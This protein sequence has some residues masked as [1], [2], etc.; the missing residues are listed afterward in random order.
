MTSDK[1]KKIEEF[2]NRIHD[3][4]QSMLTEFSEG[5]ISREQF[6]A[7]YQHYNN[8]LAIADEAL[9]SGDTDALDQV[10]G[11]TLSIRQSHMGLALGL[12]IYHNKSGTLVDTLGDFDVP[13]KQISRVLNDFSM[14]MERDQF[15]EPRVEKV[16]DQN[17][18]LYAPGQQTTVVTLFRNEPSQYQI[19]EIKRLHHDFEIANAT[20]L[21]AAQVDSRQLAYPFLVFVQ[22]KLGNS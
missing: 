15:I 5:K 1:R 17:W 16:D 18:L 9:E 14:L 19:N 22:Q 11:V 13:P 3:K 10:G 7:V 6:N 12:V 4:M 20:L 21:S 8:Q 2:R